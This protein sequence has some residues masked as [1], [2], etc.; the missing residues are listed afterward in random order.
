M[1]NLNKSNASASSQPINRTLKKK[2]MRKIILKTWVQNV[3]SPI[4]AGSFLVP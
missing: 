4:K 2:T 1:R 3:P